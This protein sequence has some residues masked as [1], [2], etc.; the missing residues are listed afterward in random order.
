MKKEAKTSSKDLSKSSKYLLFLSFQT[1]QR[2][3]VDTIF[4]IAAL[5]GLLDV[6]QQANKSMA[7]LGIIQD[8]PKCIKRALYRA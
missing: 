5:L 3:H 8:K 4:Q 6:H 7:L 2:R 1:H